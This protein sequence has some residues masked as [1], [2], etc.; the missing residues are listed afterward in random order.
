[1][2]RSGRS[3][4]GDLPVGARAGRNREPIALRKPADHSPAPHSLAIDAGGVHGFE[5]RKPFEPFMSC[6]S[7]AP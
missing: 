4:R 5:H 3:P 6:N 1:M 2:L 7:N